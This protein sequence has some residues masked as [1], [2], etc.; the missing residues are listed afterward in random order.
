MRRLVTPELA[1][2]A[3]RAVWPVLVGRSPS[4]HSRP[5]RLGNSELLVGVD[6]PA[7]LESL[8]TL[9]PQLKAKIERWLGA[10]VV[11]EIRLTIAKQPAVHTLGHPETASSIAGSS[12]GRAGTSDG[13]SGAPVDL[14][15]IKDPDLKSLVA[16]FALAYFRTA[17]PEGS[18][19]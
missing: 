19:R 15:A 5:I 7:W 14:N 12:G 10:G 2:E 16:S 18:D 9:L 6:E 11:S 13:S 3:L 4:V 17:P 1:L 8:T